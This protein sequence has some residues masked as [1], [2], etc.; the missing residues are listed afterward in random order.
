MLPLL[1]MEEFVDF[2]GNYN[3]NNLYLLEI[4]LIVVLICWGFIVG[5]IPITNS[6]LDNYIVD[7]LG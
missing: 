6:R 4:F 5:N 2:R 3:S 7:I 1:K